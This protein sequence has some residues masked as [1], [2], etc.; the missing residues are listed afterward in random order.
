MSICLV[1]AQSHSLTNLKSLLLPFLGKRRREEQWFEA[2]VQDDEKLTAQLL[3]EDPT[4]IDVVHDSD[5]G[6][7]FTGSD[8]GK[9]L[10]IASYEGCARVVALLLAV[11]P[12]LA[13]VR[14]DKGHTAL[15]LSREDKIVKILL[16]V[17]PS[18]GLIG[19]FE[20]ATALIQAAQ[21]GDLEKVRL[22]LAACPEALDM[23]DQ[24]PRTALLWAALSRHHD[25]V[26]LLLAAKPRNVRAAGYDGW[27]I[28]HREVS[29]SYVVRRAEK[30]Q[31]ILAIDPDLVRTHCH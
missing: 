2:V 16:A 1:V 27:N 8:G 3:D 6:T 20:G 10:H 26:S 31:E 25:I 19:N 15:H 7:S 30:V 23:V 13:T 11:K 18:S 4:L 24:Y 17:S 28:L 9:T 29:D 5:G 12:S 21:F 22:L 14:D